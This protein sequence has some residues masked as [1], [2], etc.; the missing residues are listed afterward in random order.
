MPE[1]NRD[2]WSKKFENRWCMGKLYLY[3]YCRRQPRD[4]C[5]LCGAQV[6]R[7]LTTN[8]CKG[9]GFVTMTNYD[10]AVLAITG[11]NG[12]QIGTRQLQVS[13]HGRNCMGFATSGGKS[14]EVCPPHSRRRRGGTL[15]TT[16]HTGEKRS[17]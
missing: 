1:E 8:K 2:P 7:D 13:T 17:D 11:L 14:N 16:D 4:R 9:F 10:E 3:F 15:H 12:Y 5:G 6:M